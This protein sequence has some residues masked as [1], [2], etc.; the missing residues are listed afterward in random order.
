[1]IESGSIRELADAIKGSTAKADAGSTVGATV[2]RTAPIWV[3]VDGS[4][5]STPIAS[6]TVAVAVGDRVSVRIEGGTATITGNLSNVSTGAV[7]TARA[8]EPVAVMA[9]TAAEVAAKANESAAVA[10]AAAQTAH[11]AAQD[12]VADAAAAQASAHSASMSAVRAQA[13]LDTIGDWDWDAEDFDPNGSYFYKDALGAHV[14]SGG[15]TDRNVL[16]D[17]GG[18]HVFSSG[19]EEGVNEIAHLGYGMT[20][21]ESGQSNSP[22]YVFGRKKDGE[23]TGAFSFIS[24]VNV[25]ASGPYSVAT[26]LS[27]GASAMGAHAEGIFSRAESRAAHAE[28][29]TTEASGLESH[30]EGNRTKAVGNAS[31]AAGTNT[32]AG[33]DYQTA[34][35]KY[36]DNKST[37]AFEIGNGD[38]TA[39]SNAFECDWDGNIIA[40]GTVSNGNVVSMADNWF[41]FGYI[42]ASS[43]GVRA[44]IPLPGFGWKSASVSGTASFTIRGGSGSTS[45][46]TAST[47]DNVTVRNGGSMLYLEW[48]LGTA[49]GGGNNVAISGFFSGLTVSL[50]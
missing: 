3:R 6:S 18:M 1:M 26:G 28:G 25:Y 13:A 23:A 27:V 46:G 8:V 21:G 7:E 45:T 38:S 31:H 37:N 35:G 33:S 30:S 17:S 41:F 43:K 19:M 44:C 34:I 15:E 9:G 36:N 42:T 4:E 32:V 49:F 39:R 48:T 2:I 50:A 24:G 5:T 12:A 40:A 16:I 11:S 20:Q 47:F 22:Y 14:M 10:E 29:W